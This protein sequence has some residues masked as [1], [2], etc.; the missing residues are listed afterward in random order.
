MNII[1]EF[2]ITIPLLMIEDAEEAF[3]REYNV[4]GT[5][6]FCLIDDNGIVVSA[7]YTDALDDSILKK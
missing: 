7:G 6:S 5:P 3:L 4:R 2:K 1:S